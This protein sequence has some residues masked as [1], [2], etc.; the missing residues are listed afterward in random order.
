MKLFIFKPSKHFRYC[1]GIIMMA[2]KNEGDLPSKVDL[3]GEGDPHK[4]YLKELK[5]HKD[6]ENAWVLANVIRINDSNIKE[7]FVDFDYNYA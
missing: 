1:R 4:L 6:I 3:A 2:A 5:S 7:G